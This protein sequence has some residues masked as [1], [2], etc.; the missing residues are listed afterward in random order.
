MISIRSKSHA[1]VDVREYAATIG[2]SG[3]VDVTVALSKASPEGGYNS[4]VAVVKQADGRTGAL[5]N[6]IELKLLDA[7]PISFGKSQLAG[8]TAASPTSLQFGPDGRLYVAEQ[9]GGIVVYTVSRA[10]ANNYQVTATESIGLIAAIPNRDDN[11]TLNPNFVGR[12]VTGLLVV[13]TATNPVIYVASSDPR[14]GAGESGADLNLDTN[15]GIL[16][17]LTWTGSQWQK[18]DLVRGLPRSEENHASNGLVLDAATNKLYIAQGGN[19][20]MGAPS[21]NFAFLPEYALSAAILSIDLN[22]IGSTTYDIPTLDDED[23]PGVNDLNDPFGGNDGKNQAK[24][25]PGGPVQVHSPGYRNPY[26]LVITQA[27]RLYSI[28]NGPNA[29]WGNVP[30]NEGPAGNATNQ[31]NEPGTTYGDSLHFVTAAGYYAGHANP[32]RSNPNNKFNSSNPQSPV[33][34]ANPIESDYKIPGPENGALIVYPNSTNGLVEY[35]ASNFGGALKGDLLS[36]GWSNLV[37]RV[38][39]NAS[40]T[41]DHAEWDFVCFGRYHPAGHYRAGRWSFVPRY[42]LVRR[43]HHRQSDRVRTGRLRRWVG[44][45]WWQSERSGRRWLL[46]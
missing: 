43:L 41:A 45:R 11:G 9:N 10:G 13:G 44:W 3:F 29:G 6:Q 28:D 23:R 30:V 25:V 34:V 17:R 31:I 4:I 7:L 40:G 2:A 22:A 27:G 5:S 1:L 14:I 36:A 16:S 8:A 18:L 24:I 26:D 39:L 33:S 42:D 38:K 12:L 21:N 37:S 20:N 35:T 15:S 46:Q 32:T 19:T